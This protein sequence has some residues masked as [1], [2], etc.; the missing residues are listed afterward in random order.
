MKLSL[1]PYFDCG[2]AFPGRPIRPKGPSY[3]SPATYLSWSR[4]KMKSASYHS[5][6]WH[7]VVGQGRRWAKRRRLRRENH[8]TRCAAFITGCQRSGTK[9]LLRTLDQSPLVWTHD[10]RHRDLAY[11]LQRDPAYQI[12]S[13]GSLARLA[14][15]EQLTELIHCHQAPVVAFHSLADSQQIDRIL[16]GIPEAVAIWIYRHYADVAQSA[17]QLWG[18]HQ[19]DLV[20]RFHLRQFDLLKWRG[21]NIS[22]DA[23]KKL[24]ACYQ[25]C[26]TPLEGGALMWFVRNQLLFQLG[27]AASPRVLLVKYEDLV[28]RPRDHFPEVFRFVGLPFEPRFVDHIFATSVGKSKTENYSAEVR[29]LCDSLMDRLDQVYASRQSAA[30]RE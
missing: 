28:T 30:P 19:L 23:L 6:S 13:G 17:V 24:D 15:I 1:I 9:M 26:L 16:G 20:R 10:H 5:S 12:S 2:T 8:P 22:E 4:N 3:F 29:T 11:G 21:E 25:P 7:K 18:E 14:P 27:L